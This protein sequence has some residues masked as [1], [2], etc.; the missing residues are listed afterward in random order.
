MPL[1]SLI[2]EIKTGS[3]E[4]GIR[5][6]LVRMY[7]NPNFGKPDE[8]ESIELI[9]HDREGDRIHASMKFQLWKKLII[10]LREGSLYC[11]RNFVVSE[12]KSTFKTTSNKLKIY[13]I[14]STSF[15][16]FGDLK[17]S[18]L[19]YNFRDYREF[20]IDKE[21]D[22]NLLIDVMGR[23]ISFQPPVITN[24]IA[25]Q[26]LDFRIADIQNNQITC[27]VWE[28]YMENLLPILERER[29]GPIII[30]LQFARAKRVRGEIKISNTYHVT[31]L[32]VNGDD[33]EFKQFR[34]RLNDQGQGSINKVMS[35][36]YYEIF[37]VFAQGN[38]KVRSLA[39]LSQMKE[40][41]EYSI[42]ATIVDIETTNDHWYLACQ[43]CAHKIFSGDE[44]FKCGHCKSVNN[45][46]IYRYKIE[47]RVIDESGSA[48][49]LLWNKACLELIGKSANEL[50]MQKDENNADIQALI[51]QSLLDKKAL[52]EVQVT[53][54]KKVRN[55]D[56][57]TVSRATAEE[58][59]KE[60]YIQKNCD[61][62]ES[63]VQDSEIGEKISKEDIKI[64]AKGMEKS[65]KE[66][67]LEEKQTSNEEGIL[68]AGDFQTNGENVIENL[69]NPSEEARQN[70]GLG[71]TQIDAV[72][73]SKR[74]RI[75]IKQE[76]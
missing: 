13:F 14:N 49:L 58:D 67:A 8:I 65:Y 16:K 19:M 35:L 69:N 34:E 57:Y 25:A 53:S 17:F 27:S 9:L 33:A 10:E 6:R 47:V 43:N 55:S 64:N 73:N 61:S 54:D 52:F 31:K 2:R 30:A 45:E 21:V 60:L 22:E 29:N 36:T 11:I 63:A 24:G 4:W 44:N 20:A 51:E 48:R 32:I 15:F 70:T 74:K 7:R 56:Y 1:F 42:D 5:G 40:D 12:N 75:K 38:A 68:G 3:T 46:H 26:R 37:D 76:K 50:K 62:Q 59:I 39:Y 41:N 23:V 18:R 66:T 28:E 71:D 72:Y